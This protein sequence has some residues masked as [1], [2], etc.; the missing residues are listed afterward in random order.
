MKKE[1]QMTLLFCL[2]LGVGFFLK[3]E[4]P[5]ASGKLE[6]DYPHE[7]VDAWEY[8]VRPGTGEWIAL[9]STEKRREACRI[10]QETLDAMNAET[11]L[12]TALDYPFCT[13][14]WA[15]DSLEDG[16]RSQLTHNSALA[17]LAVR[18]D[19]R[20]AVQARLEDMEAWLDEVGRTRSAESEHQYSCLLIFAE[21][22]E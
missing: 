21:Y 2:L 6:V 22:M 7:T 1:F 18:D 17:S 8:P 13:D 14:M 12:E 4:D 11:L 20:E 5:A 15:F 9:G 10:P 19:G 16:Y 3:P